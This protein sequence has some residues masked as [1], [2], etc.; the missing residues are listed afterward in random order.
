MRLEMKVLR[1][2]RK[3]DPRI[4]IAEKLMVSPKR[5]LEALRF[6]EEKSLLEKAGER[7]YGITGRF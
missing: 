2:C 6:L 1:L 5:V 7:A 3:R 4:E